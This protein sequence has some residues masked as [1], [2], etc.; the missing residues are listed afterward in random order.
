MLP[1][2]FVARNIETGEVSWE[3]GLGVDKATFSYDEIYCEDR[4]LFEDNKHEIKQY[5]GKKDIDGCKVYEGDRLYNGYVFAYVKY[6]IEHAAF[7][8]EYLHNSSLDYL[9]IALE[10]GFKVG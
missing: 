1:K 3:F 8:I 5:T 4:P 6:S 9:H 2:V 10:K 7:M